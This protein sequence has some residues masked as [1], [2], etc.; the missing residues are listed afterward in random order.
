M[1]AASNYTENNVINAMLR[2]VAFPLP[3][4][5]YVSLHTADPGESG[6]NEVSTSAWPAYSRRDTAVGGAI[7]SGWAA[8][9]DGVTT[10]L[11]QIPFP[12][13]NGAGDVTV[14]HW[15]L[16]DAI[17]GGNMLTHAA[18]QTPRTLHIGDVRRPG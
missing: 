16:Y 17:T 10:N 15:A 18:L 4:A 8:P 14:T 13:Q 12:G 1:S 9:T 6:G 3:S 5:V 7:A 2:G 11:K